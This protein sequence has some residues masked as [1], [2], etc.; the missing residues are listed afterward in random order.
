MHK[1]IIENDQLKTSSNEVLL[2][3]NNTITI[4]SSGEYTI[5][6][7]NCKKIS[8]EMKVEKNVTAK[9]FI[10][11]VGNDIQINNHYLLEKN[12]QLLLFQF[13]YNKNVWENTTIDLNGELASFNSGFSSISRGIEEY[14]I[15]VNHNACKVS[16]NIKNKC[17][18][19]DKSAITLEINSVLGKG[20]TDCLMDQ[21][22]RILTLGEV[23]AKILPNMFIDENSVNAKHGSIIGG[24]REE[25]I[26]YLMSRGISYQ[27][28]V[29]LLIKG[30]IFS[31][32]MVDMEKRAMIFEIIQ[33]L[34]GE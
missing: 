17:I 23:D 29:H 8:L 15:I 24:F 13:Y 4:I 28:A 11:S 20:N 34:R 31:N 27:E 14:H 5:E 12:S 10:S 33:N 26:F 30:F 16:S 18:G 3:K 21:T 9:V 25:E 2:L 1:I 22:S 7:R 19:L 6:Y 32:L